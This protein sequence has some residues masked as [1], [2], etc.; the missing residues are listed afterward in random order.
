MN[1]LKTNF[2]KT[3][4]LGVYRLFIYYYLFLIVIL[5]PPLRYCYQFSDQHL[6]VRK[7]MESCQQSMCLA[8]LHSKARY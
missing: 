2:V 3:L 5:I 1:V 4:H 6:Q 7:Q 8:H